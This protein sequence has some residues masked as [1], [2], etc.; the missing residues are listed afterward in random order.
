MAVIGTTA[1]VL[2]AEHRKSTFRSGWAHDYFGDV[3]VL[4]TKGGDLEARYADLQGE[5]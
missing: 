5:R 4:S 2:K 3:V 1:R